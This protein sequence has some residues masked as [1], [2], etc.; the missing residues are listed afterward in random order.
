MV[1]A[2]KL[3]KPVRSASGVIIVA[4]MTK[5]FPCPH[6]R[7][8]YCPGGPD[9]GTPQSYLEDSPAVARALRFNFD[10]YEQVRHRLSQYVAMGHEPSKI[11][12]IFMGGTFTALPLDYQEWFVTM[13]IEACNRFPKGKPKGFISLEKAQ[14]ANEKAKVRVVGITFETRPDWCKERHVDWM[15]K[16]GGTRVEIGV[17]SIYDDVLLKVERGHTVKDSIEATRILKDSGFKVVYH[18]MPG[19]PGSDLDR[20]IE[21]FK[22]IFS[23][24]R[25]RPDMLKIYPTLVIPGTKLYELWRK[26]KYRAITDDEFIE[27]LLKIMPLIPRWV[28]IM[29]IQRDVPVHHVVAGL[30]LG[31]IRQIVEREIITRGIKCKEIRFREAGL[32]YIK[33]G[34]LPDPNYVQLIREDYEA[35]EGMEVFLSFEDTKNDILL[36]FIRMRIPSRKAHRWEVDEKTAII[37]ELHVYG[38]QVPIGKREELAWQHKGYGRRLLA[39]A[40]R[41]AVEEYDCRRMLIIS[42]IGVREYYRRFGYYRLPN[43]MYMFKHLV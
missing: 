40:E 27:F 9:Y 38:P 28:R 21:M 37:R 43:S 1:Q 30:M 42:G 22:T 17:Q 14:T 25:F 41:I 12:L 39:E 15:L 19:L 31:N 23:D 3:K 26:G 32:Q 8:I 7:C 16:L 10:P 20:D 18:L 13:A 2:K 33:Y 6:G 36:G 11:E 5:P 29:R 35:S 34:K 4:V 24:P